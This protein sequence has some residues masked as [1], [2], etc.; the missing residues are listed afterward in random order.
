[1]QA[2]GNSDEAERL[3]RES[4]AVQAKETP[5]NDCHIQV[6][7]A[8]ANNLAHKGQID[9]AIP[10]YAEALDLLEKLTTRHGGTD[11]VRAS[12]RA[13]HQ[14]HYREYADLLI[15][16]GKTD[17]AF[18]VLERSRAR[19]LLETL[20][21]AHVD[22][23]R[24]ADPAL[25]ANARALMAELR[26]KQERRARLFGEQHSDEQ[27]RAIEKEIGDRTAEYQALQ[28]QI[29][30]G[31]QSYATLSQP[32]DA[33]EIQ[34]QLLDPDTLLIEYFLG[35]ERSLAFAVTPNSLQ[36]M[37]LPKRAQIEKSARGVYALLTAR[38]RVIQGETPAHSQERWRKAE[39]DYAQASQVLSRMI[40]GP[41]A[42]QLGERFSNKRLLIVTDG[43]LAYIP[44]AMLADP[45]TL[46]AFQP[47]G[48]P[49]VVNHEIVNLPS[50]SVLAVLRQQQ[51]ARPRAA[52]AI[53]VLA[54][55][56]FDKHDKRIRGLRT[57]HARS[58]SRESQPSGMLSAFSGSPATA[59]LTRSV[60][61]VGV[62]GRGGAILT[63]LRYSRQ[64][65][66]AIMAVTPSGRGME[67]L[68]FA[69]N[70]T[71]ATNPDLS[72]YR[73]VHFATHG[74]LDS[75]R[76]EL[77]GLVLSLVDENGNPQDGF[78]GL[79]DI[80]NLNLPA[81]L[82]VLSACETGLGKEING[83]GVIGLTRGFMY[84]GATR[85][86]ASLWKVSDVATAR[87][88]ASFYQS[89]EKDGL[90]PAAAL[91]AAQTA[92]WKQKR[93]RSPYYWAAFQI[94]GEWK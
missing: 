91:R 86:V 31:S 9:A 11:E 38:N 83:E 74:L 1:V 34:G 78:L 52:K 69:A 85:V 46:Q 82:V 49:L 19:T 27:I 45:Q 73:V 88:M 3:Y 79:E 84:A 4:L 39:A 2:L 77:S 20:L 59:L 33:K 42:K 66:D 32:L 87:L 22:I 94:Q 10:M 43:A 17:A 93:W 6:L 44:F 47:A 65:A 53:A 54:D 55:P 89:M 81:D 23:Y 30:A 29:R 25:V 70:R 58:A 71:T 41:I 40:L 62:G 61:D 7:T 13:E 92:M 80:Y 5:G 26:S 18:D 35:E 60:S 90:A 48:T 12:F 67:A 72:N 56:V 51:R 50:A 36:V 57:Q 64:E 21:A 28:E 75:A 63:R 14:K 24:G 15:G 68:D 37:V 16:K 8:L 76:P